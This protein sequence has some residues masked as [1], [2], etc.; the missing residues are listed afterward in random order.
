MAFLLDADVI[1]EAERGSFDL[2]A[3]VEK[4]P[5]DQMML[6]SAT[7]A[8]LLFAVERADGARRIRRQ[9]HVER[10]LQV[11]KVLPYTERSAFEHFRLRR[12]LQGKSV[13]DRDQMLAAIAFEH[14]ADLA[15]FGPSRFAGISYLRVVKPA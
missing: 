2:F 7:V 3:W 10:I 6:A 11:L 1:I 12:E 9:Q 15:T 4:H 8:E 14:H 5:E 13:A